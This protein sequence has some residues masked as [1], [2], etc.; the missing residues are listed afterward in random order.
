[1]NLFN[2]LRGEGVL[3][4]LLKKC[5]RNKRGNLCFQDFSYIWNEPIFLD[6]SFKIFC[7]FFSNFSLLC[8]F[9]LTNFENDIF[10]EI[11]AA[12]VLRLLR[13]NIPAAVQGT[14]KTLCFLWGVLNYP[15]L[16]IFRE[17][18]GRGLNTGFKKTPDYENLEDERR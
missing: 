13:Q 18:A 14:I 6:S 8:D 3:N 16:L 10:H 4:Y 17:I 7:L 12:A 1:M 9:F 5:A 2:L 11:P 15:S